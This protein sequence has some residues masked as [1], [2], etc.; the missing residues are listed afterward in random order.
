MGNNDEWSLGVVVKIPLGNREAKGKL[1]IAQLEA[2]QGLLILKKLEQEILIE[3]DNAIRSAET[4]MQRIK[5]AKVSKR[6][7]AESLQ[8]EEIKLKE[9]L[10]TSHD[11]LQ[12][13]DDLVEARSREIIAVIDYNKSLVELSRVKG[14][15]LQEEGISISDN[16]VTM[17]R[18]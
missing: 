8:A 18:R 6:L 11:V 15:L 13:Q 4:N 1:T 17:V 16:S 5:A 9:G 7:A 3:I 2:R 10:S 12:F 14:T